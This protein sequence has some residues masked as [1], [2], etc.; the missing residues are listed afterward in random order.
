MDGLLQMHLVTVGIPETR[1]ISPPSPQHPET[2]ALTD[3]KQTPTQATDASYQPEPHHCPKH[4]AFGIHN[5]PSSVL[6]RPVFP[7]KC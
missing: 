1:E 6:P 2:M 5:K 3:T 4:E 7:V